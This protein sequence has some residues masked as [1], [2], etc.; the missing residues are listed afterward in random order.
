MRA[1]V[2]RRAC[3]YGGGAPGAAGVCSG[4]RLFTAVHGSSR[5]FTAYSRS[6]TVCSRYGAASV[7]GGH[8]QFTV[9]VQPVHSQHSV[10]A[11]CTHA[12]QRDPH[13]GKPVIGVHGMI[14]YVMDCVLTA[15]CQHQ[16]MNTTGEPCSEMTCVVFSRCNAQPASGLT[17]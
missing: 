13:M 14:T 5:G 12:G 10:Y 3:G 2:I 6:F 9:C 8:S 11:Q 4:A 7:S 1:H 16:F 15:A 17:T